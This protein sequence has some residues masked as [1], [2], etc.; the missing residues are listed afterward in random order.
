MSD[1]IMPAFIRFPDE[2]AIIGR[3]LAGYGEL[4]FELA[5]CLSHFLF[6]EEAAFQALFRIRTASGR[7]DLA[8]ALLRKP[9]SEIGLG[10]QYADAYSAM[11]YCS[12][13]RNQYAHC[14]WT[15][16]QGRVEQLAFMQLD[17]AVR[18]VDFNVV[19]HKTVSLALLQEQ[20]DYFAYALRCFW[21]LTNEAEVKQGKLNANPFS[22]PPKIQ[23]PPLHS[24][25]TLS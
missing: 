2:A 4:E 21:F 14:H 10:S 13:I 18:G 7:I 9:I 22:V 19:P 25:L 11:R 24:P 3:L 6:S 17:D 8:D 12:R 1:K 15:V 16:T 23:A 20:E 5:M